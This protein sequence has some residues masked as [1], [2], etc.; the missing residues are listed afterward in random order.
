MKKKIEFDENEFF[1]ILFISRDVQIKNLS[2]LISSKDRQPPHYENVFKDIKALFSQKIIAETLPRPSQ[3]IEAIMAK[4][5]RIFDFY[6]DTFLSHVEKLMKSET[7][8]VRFYRFKV[9]DPN[10]KCLLS[11]KSRRRK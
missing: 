8:T 2:S 11:K 9:L 10:N 6:R 7:S 5:I 3:G 4:F 1:E